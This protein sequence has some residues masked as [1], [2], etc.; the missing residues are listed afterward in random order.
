MAFDANLVKMLLEQQELQQQEFQE[1]LLCWLMEQLRKGKVEERSRISRD[2]GRVILESTIKLFDKSTCNFAF[3]EDGLKSA[4]RYKG[5]EDLFTVAKLDDAPGTR[6]LLHKLDTAVHTKY[7][8]HTLPKN[9][10]ELTFGETVKILTELSGPQ[11]S[12]FS[13]RCHCLKLVKQASNNF[14]TMGNSKLKAR[15]VQ[16]GRT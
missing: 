1:S 14:V 13:V 12:Q 2:E 9:P 10:R 8:N 15:E 11:R 5:C 16:T 4:A 3:N 6:F 7:V